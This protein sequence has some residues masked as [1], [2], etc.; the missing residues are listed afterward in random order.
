VGTRGSIAEFQESIEAV[1]E[2]DI[3]DTI[4]AMN[5]AAF[6]TS[7]DQ[8][9]LREV[10]LEYREVFRPTKRSMRGPGFSIKCYAALRMRPLS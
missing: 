2:E 3:K 9:A 10:L 8:K 7:E 4:K 6:G 5:F 1:S